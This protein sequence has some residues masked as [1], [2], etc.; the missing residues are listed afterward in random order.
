MSAV[1]KVRRDDGHPREAW[2]DKEIFLK[3]STSR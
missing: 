3:G 1:V 2:R